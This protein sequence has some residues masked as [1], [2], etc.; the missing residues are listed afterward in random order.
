MDTSED[1]APASGDRTEDNDDVTMTEAGKTISAS[2]SG[3]VLCPEPFVKGKSVMTA[4]LSKLQSHHPV[5]FSETI[6]DPQLIIALDEVAH[7]GK[8]VNYGGVSWKPADVLCRTISAYSNFIKLPIWVTFTST[9]S[10]IADFAAPNITR[11]SLHL[12]AAS[13]LTSSQTVRSA[14]SWEANQS[15]LR[16][17]R[18]GSTNLHLN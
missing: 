17:A 3:N 7:L 6:H 9:E 16:F 1:P 11:E 4:A 13:Y 12:C 18:P 10:H 2:S 8:V 15:S 14:Y 5:L